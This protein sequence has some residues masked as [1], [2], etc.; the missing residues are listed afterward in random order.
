MNKW[1]LYLREQLLNESNLV[2]ELLSIDEAVQGYCVS[3]NELLLFLEKNLY[4]N[5]FFSF[6][7]NNSCFLVEGD[8]YDFIFI[9]N[10]LINFKN[11]VNVCKNNYAI[12]R[13]ILKKYD[14][15]L[16]RNG[17]I[18]NLN[19]VFNDYYSCSGEIIYVLGSEEFYEESVND[20]VNKINFLKID[21]KGY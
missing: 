14:E 11:K 4:N 13:W 9:L 5:Q 3:Y 19:I 20:F 6:E 1:I 18:N 2:V 21:R 16:L 8:P 12:N 15:F 10:D 17:Y 7:V